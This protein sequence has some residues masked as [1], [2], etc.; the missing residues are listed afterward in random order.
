VCAITLRVEASIF[1]TAPQQGQVTSKLDSRF[2]TRD[3]T[4]IEVSAA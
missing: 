4:A 3:H 1:R 2:T